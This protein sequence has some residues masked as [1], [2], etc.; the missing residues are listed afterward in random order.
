MDIT[1]YAGRNL[2]PLEINTLFC[3]QEKEYW[4]ASGDGGIGLS[5]H[6]KTCHPI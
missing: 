1:V 3:L 6:K 5:P 2:P 4:G